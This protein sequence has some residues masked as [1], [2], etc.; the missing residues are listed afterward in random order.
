MYRE[1][2]PTEP[3]Q[4]VEKVRKRPGRPRSKPVVE[5][6][7]EV[8]AP[9][10]IAFER[11]TR[12]NITAK[13]LRAMELEAK[14]MELQAVSGNAN[15]RVNRKGDADGRQSRQRTPAQLAAT[16]RLVEATKLRRMKKKDD[17]KQEPMGEHQAVVKNIIG[18]LNQ[19]KVKKV[20]EENEKSEQDKIKAQKKKASLAMLD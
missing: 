15:L 17:E 9:D 4:I 7:K 8:Y 12:Q 16:A 20:E 19:N 6:T 18:A 14:L 5:V 1:D 11:P 10:V 13:Q 2:L 3:I